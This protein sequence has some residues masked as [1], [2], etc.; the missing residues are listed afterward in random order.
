MLHQG[1]E[2]EDGNYKKRLYTPTFIT[3]EICNGISLYFIVDSWHH[4]IIYS[5]DLD[6]PIKEWKLLTENI[7]GPLSLAT[8]GELIITEDTGRHG[9][10]V[11]KCIDY[12]T[13]NYA[14][15]ISDAGMR[16]HRTIYDDNTQLF[17]CIGS[18]SQNI[19]AI[20]NESGTARVRYN[21][22][23]PFLEECYVR[24]IRIIDGMMYMISANDYIFVCEYRDASYDIIDKIHIGSQF[25]GANDVFKIGDYF[26]L[27]ASP[28]K[29]IRIKNLKDISTGNYEDLYS[30]LGMK[31]TPYFISEFNEKY[32]I[33][34]IA[35]ASRINSFK[36][37]NNQIKDFKT[38]IDDGEPAKAD[39]NRF[40]ALPK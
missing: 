27:T 7:A 25:V 5:K 4:R 34:E 29:F 1:I 31:G 35:Q 17:Y 13:F 10:M 14:Q 24:A 32:W 9:L 23:L 18:F 33:T 36:V 26:Y 16:P 39:L 20:R 3:K 2:N 12:E 19:I 11:F 15:Y 38:F 8:D 37:E 22:K 21:Y 40:Y 28:Q 30:D 6:L